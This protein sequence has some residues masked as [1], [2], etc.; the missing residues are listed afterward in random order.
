[1]KNDICCIFYQVDLTGGRLFK[2]DWH[3]NRLQ[4]IGYKKWVL[5]KE[6]KENIFLNTARAQLCL[7]R[8]KNDAAWNE[9]L[10]PANK[11]SRYPAY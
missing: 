11:I 10:F 9:I 4:R 3:R 6:S 2:W 5:S 1:M 8:P 7:S